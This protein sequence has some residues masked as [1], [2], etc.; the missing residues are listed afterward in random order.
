MMNSLLSAELKLLK[1]NNMTN[2]DNR[3]RI[4]LPLIFAIILVAGVFIGRYI[5][6]L[7]GAMSPNSLMIYPQEDKVETVLNL[8]K[9]EYVDTINMSEL[10]EKVIPHIIENLDPHSVYIPAKDLKEV[11]SFLNNNL[12]KPMHPYLFLLIDISA[13]PLFS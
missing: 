10:E 8:I 1:K 2:R 4:Y 6:S 13:I 9:E 11:N 5:F 12:T 3:S 7:P